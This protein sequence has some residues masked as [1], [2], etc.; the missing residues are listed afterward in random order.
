MAVIAPLVW[1]KAHDSDQCPVNLYATICALRW[2]WLVETVLQVT[3]LTFSFST[4]GDIAVGSLKSRHSLAWR[5][6]SHE[7][8]SRSPAESPF[9][10]D[11]QVRGPFLTWM[12]KCC[13]VLEFPFARSSVIVT[14][15]IFRFT[16]CF[17]GDEKVFPAAAGERTESYLLRVSLAK[18]FLLRIARHEAWREIGKSWEPFRAQCTKRIHCWQN[19]SRSLL[20]NRISEVRKLLAENL[21]DSKVF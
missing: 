6:T 17:T 21:I 5:M 15:C 16:L 2:L 20:D 9:S 1:Y 8:L 3:I 11:A 18:D 19:G 7:L 14:A 4:I 10:C 12:A 13:A